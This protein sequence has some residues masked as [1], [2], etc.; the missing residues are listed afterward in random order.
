MLI[1]NSVVRNPLI[2]NKQGYSEVFV[3]LSYNVI[4]YIVVDGG[5]CSHCDGVYLNIPLIFYTRNISL[6]LFSAFRVRVCS[7]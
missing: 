4:F 1:A 7:I 5:I 3:K 6:P 2:S